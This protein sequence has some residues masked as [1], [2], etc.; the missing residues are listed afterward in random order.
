MRKHLLAKAHI[1]KLIKLTQSEV[2]E[3]TSSTVE[4]TAL[5]IVRRHVS[6]GI[7]IVSAQGKIIFDIRF[8]PY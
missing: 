8:D 1:A 3:L 7:K 4:E 5:A 6:R 2:T